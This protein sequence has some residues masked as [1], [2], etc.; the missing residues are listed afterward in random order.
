MKLLNPLILFFVGGFLFLLTITFCWFPLF[1]ALNFKALTF[2]PTFISST[3]NDIQKIANEK[4]EKINGGNNIDEV[5]EVIA[6]NINNSK[7][8]SAKENK[9]PKKNISYKDI[10][11]RFK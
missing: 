5:E 9:S 4:A 1:E 10:M 6:V 8:T 11:D 2:L 7:S 3:V